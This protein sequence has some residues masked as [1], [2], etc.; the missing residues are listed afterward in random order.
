MTQIMQLV[1]K[2]CVLTVLMIILIIFTQKKK[3]TIALTT[4][5]TS[6]RLQ[7]Q[8]TIFETLRWNVLTFDRG[9]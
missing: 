3:F 1:E 7:I 9:Q 2:K 4:F 6:N 5:T 8:T